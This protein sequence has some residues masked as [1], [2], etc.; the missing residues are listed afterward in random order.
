ESDTSSVASGLL[1]F[2]SLLLPLYLLSV[3]AEAWVAR[4]LVD[5]SHRQKAWRWAWLANLVT[6]ALISAALMAL[7]VIDWLTRPDMTAFR[8]HYSWRGRAGAGRCGKQ[9][10]V[11]EQREFPDGR[12]AR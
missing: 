5:E 3:V 2:V 8:L 11:G 6:Y 1:F 9:E 12:R 10:R 4:R 7:T